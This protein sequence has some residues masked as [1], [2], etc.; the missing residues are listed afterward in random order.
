MKKI[1]L[2]VIFGFFLFVNVYAQNNNEAGRL[3]DIKGSVEIIRAE[4]VLMANENIGIFKDDIISVKK[5]SSV[6]IKL[7]NSKIEQISGEKKIK[8]SEIVSNQQNKK[9]LKKI[10]LSKI[11]N[12]DIDKKDRISVTVVA[13]VR[14]DDK[15]VKTKLTRDYNWIDYNEDN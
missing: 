5:N 12:V 4:K 6:S 8:V 7:N 2:V 1:I 11:K 13:G 15:R 9:I 10:D 14:A 3:S